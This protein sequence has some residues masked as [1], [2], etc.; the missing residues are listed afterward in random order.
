MLVLGILALAV[1]LLGA[2]AND[3]GQK[4]RKP[5][6]P[7]LASSEANAFHIFNAIQSAGRLWGSALRHNG[8]SFFPAVMAKG[9]LL[10]HGDRHEQPPAGPEWLAFGIEHAEMFSR[11]HEKGQR[12]VQQQVRG[13]WEREEGGKNNSRGYLQ[14]YTANRDVLLLY[15]DGMAAAKSHVGTLDSQDLVLR[16]NRT[17]PWSDKMDEL[18]RVRDI[19]Q[20]VIAWGFDGF[21][22]SEIGHEVVYCDLSNGLNL[23]SSTRSFMPQDRLSAAR[24]LLYQ[25]ARTA[26]HEY[27]GLPR[28]QLRLDFSSMVSGFFFPID[29]SST[30]PERPD[31]MRLGSASLNELKDIKSYLQD[32][33]LRPRRFTIDWQAITDSVVLRFSDWLALITT[34]KLSIGE[35]LEELGRITMLYIDAPSLPGDIYGEAKNHSEAFQRCKRH[36]LT[37]TYLVRKEWNAD[38]Y[39]IH[40]AVQAVTSDICQIILETRASFAALGRPRV[41]TGVQIQMGPA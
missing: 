15:L 10:Y 7:S 20:I 27:D 37:P 36:Y 39:Y 4:G 34:D 30:N 17:G 13:L 40:A 23:L 11:S 24:L 29:I 31:L 21:V 41:A 22:R 12:Q 32:I 1:F 9:T 19:C 14:M 35:F 3:T 33:C 8:F 28:G 6:E 26:S 25:M 5:I 18:G 38:D 16:E 2:T